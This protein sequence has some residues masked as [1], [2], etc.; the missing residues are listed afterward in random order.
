MLSSR[1]RDEENGDTLGDLFEGAFLAWSYA[2]CDGI[3]RPSV[4]QHLCLFTCIQCSISASR[5]TLSVLPVT[6]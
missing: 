2:S 5:S 1:M 3:H 6:P 4:L